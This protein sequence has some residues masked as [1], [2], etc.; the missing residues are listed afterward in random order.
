MTFKLCQWGREVPASQ[1]NWPQWTLAVCTNLNVGHQPCTKA[2]TR[3]CTISQ[4]AS[5]TTDFTFSLTL[6]R[7]HQQPLRW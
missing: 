7:T 1:V 5:D 4:A 3:E 2:H 6:T